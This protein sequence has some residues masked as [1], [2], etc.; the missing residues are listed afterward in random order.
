VDGVSWRIL[1]EDLETAYRQVSSGRPVDLG[2]KTT[3]Y[4]Q[5]AH[6][7]SEHVRSG[8]FDADL[9]YWTAVPAG[10][11]ADLP[12]DRYG[13]NTV[14]S[15]GVVSVRLDSD[16]T[17]ALLHRVPG[18][19]RT[20]VND[21]LLAA[22]GR[23]LSNW[24]GRDR[25]LIAMEG[26]G[27]E[28][29]LDRVDVSR[30]VGWFTTKYPV[31]LAIPASADWG[32]HLKSVK[33][34]L[35]A[36]PARGLSYEALRYL[37]PPD[38][39]AGTLRDDPSP[40][41]CF[42]YHGQWGV[43]ADKDGFYRTLLDQIG[44]NFAPDSN[45]PYLL[46]VVGAVENGELELS[47]TYSGQVHDEATVRRLADEMMQALRE[48]VERCAQPDAGGCTPSD[49]PLARLDQAQVDRIAGDGRSVEDIYRLTP[50][51]AGMLFHSLV[52]TESHTYVDQL[53]LRLSGVPDPQ[54]LGTA[55]QRVVDRTPVL[56]SSVV[57]EGMDE[58][59]QVVHRGVSV[60]VAYHDWRELS[61]PDRD[62]QLRRVLA[63]DRTGLTLSEPPLLRLT[64]ARLS[65]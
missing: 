44:Q 40:Q 25:V 59:L 23:V 17:D 11:P 21:V 10:V 6:R 31:A 14:G 42:N 63:E 36:L 16:A 41:I 24:T 45:R 30:T 46:D 13:R 32:D 28:E 52:D 18:T 65:E 35:R 29:L 62:L 37:S 7:L 26:H 5:W 9:A 39:P 49:F 61:E 34:Q 58:P 47:W 60:P 55:W 8:R 1:L 56:R 22:L 50:L 4:R 33:E 20:Q 3:G 64:I 43:S 15:T 12:V 54:A 27:R 57:W 51:Q 19:Y 2:P 53:R 48:I 38:V